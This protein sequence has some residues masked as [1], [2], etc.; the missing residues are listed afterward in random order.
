MLTFFR[1]FKGFLVILLVGWAFNAEAQSNSFEK[2]LREMEQ[3]VTA[4]ESIHDEASAARAAEIMGAS[5]A[6]IEPLL[7]GMDSWNEAE[8]KY[9]ALN[10]SEDFSNVSMRMSNSL[11]RMVQ[12][13]DY[14]D[15]FIEHMQNMPT[16]EPNQ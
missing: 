13:P 5:F 16:F 10:Y 15:L 4:M 11:M 8:W 6:R 9:F 14:M 7:Q 3:I 2:Y 12:N 1:G